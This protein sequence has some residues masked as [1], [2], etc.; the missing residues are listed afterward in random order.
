MSKH[1]KAAIDFLGQRTPALDVLAG[2]LRACATAHDLAWTVCDFAGRAL[3][4]DDLIVYLADS[5]G[6]SLVQHAAWG[7]K[8]V[9]E[10]MIEHRITLRIGQGI[11]GSCALTGITQL[12][13]DTRLDPRYVPDDEARLSEMA[14]AIRQDG[15]VLGVIDSE[16]PE[17]YAYDTPHVEALEAIAAV[18]AEALSKL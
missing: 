15:R 17:A 13:P 6:R 18:A 3:E 2:K 8:R 4:L 5:D 12:I 9:A 7:A 14:V 11:V 1:L 10:R 16:A